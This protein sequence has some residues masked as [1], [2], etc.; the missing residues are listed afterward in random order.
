MQAEPEFDRLGKRLKGE[1]RKVTPAIKGVCTR[2]KERGK[3]RKREWQR[4]RERE[5]EKGG[6]DGEGGE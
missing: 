4:E 3:G 1:L 2:E 5:R 6:Q